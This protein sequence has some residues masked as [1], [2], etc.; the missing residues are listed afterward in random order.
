MHFGAAGGTRSTFGMPA[1][2]FPILALDVFDTGPTGFGLLAAEQPIGERTEPERT[3][4]QRRGMAVALGRSS[5]SRTHGRCIGAAHNAGGER[6]L[7]GRAVHL[8]RQIVRIERPLGR[9]DR[10]ARA[11]VGRRPD[12]LRQRDVLFVRRHAHL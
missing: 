8:D 1:S 2:R 6:L 9:L 10:A 7:L 5:A 12:Q 11:R 3:A 4:L